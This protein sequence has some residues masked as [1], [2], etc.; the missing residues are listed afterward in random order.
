MGIQDSMDYL[1][2]LGYVIDGLSNEDI[3]YL[4]ETLAMES[5]QEDDGG[6]WC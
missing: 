2:D 1:Q 4:V 3:L 5:D 6:H